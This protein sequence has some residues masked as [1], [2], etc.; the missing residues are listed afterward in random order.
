MKCF[1]IANKRNGQ[2]LKPD[3]EIIKIKNVG[4]Y[5]RKKINLILSYSYLN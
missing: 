4:G 5:I 2:N 3:H 1:Y